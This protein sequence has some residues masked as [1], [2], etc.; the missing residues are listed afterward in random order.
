LLEELGIPRPLGKS[1]FSVV[2]AVQAADKI[3]YPVLVR[4]SYVLGGRA[5]EIVYNQKELE[6][7][8]ATAVKVNREQPVL[9]DKYLLGKEIEV[10]AVGDGKEVLIPGIMQHIERAGVHSGDSMAVFPAHN[11][12]SEIQN[13]VTDYTTRLALAL[14]VKGLI[15]IQFV[16]FQNELYVIEVNPRSSRT[17][18]FISK[19]T[20]VP[21]VKLA[22]E[23]ALG[24]A[25]PA[26]VD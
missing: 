16:E 2:D 9:V 24:I 15:N 26:R 14:K 19:I 1:V 13:K 3:G 18:P 22:T 21:M 8:M 5:M 17:V 25:E 12:S 7:Y 23:A 20:G 6:Q 4:P 10:D 11:I